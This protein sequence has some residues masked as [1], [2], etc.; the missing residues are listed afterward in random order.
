MYDRVYAAMADAK[1][2]APMDELE[3]YFINR[4]GIQ[5]KTEKEVSGHNIKHHLSNPQYA[6]FEDEVGTDTKHIDDENNGGQSYIS[7]KVMKNNLFSS[8]ALSYFTFMGMTAATG[9]S[10]LCI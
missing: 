6:L 3:Y 5:I 10:V 8:K 1:V 2:A 9:E 4:T 7:I